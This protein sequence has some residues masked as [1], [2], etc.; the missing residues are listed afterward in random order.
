L[1]IT[2]LKVTTGR[3]CLFWH[4]RNRHLSK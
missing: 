1:S 3:C 4:V 2:F